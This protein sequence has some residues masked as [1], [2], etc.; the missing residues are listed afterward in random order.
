METNAKIPSASVHGSEA[1][2]D[3]LDKIYTLND[4]WKLCAVRPVTSLIQPVQF[5]PKVM[6]RVY[7]EEYN[8]PDETEWDLA[9]PHAHIFCQND[10]EPCIEYAFLPFTCAGEIEWLEMMVK[11]QEFL[12]PALQRWGLFRLIRG[13]PRVPLSHL[14]HQGANMLVDYYDGVGA[15]SLR[16]VGLPSGMTFAGVQ[17]DYLF[18]R[19]VVSWMDR[20][21]RDI[22]NCPIW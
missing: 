9:Y 12:R 22:F 15:A 10:G 16:R 7:F 11:T 6:F 21:N 4:D 8:I 19:E 18:L 17:S 5:V 14:Y 1:Q 3:I 13:G 2:V 20:F